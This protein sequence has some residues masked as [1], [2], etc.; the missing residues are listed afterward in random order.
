[1]TLSTPEQSLGF[2]TRGNLGGSATG[3]P[4]SVETHG[5]LDRSTLCTNERR[6]AA[7]AKKDWACLDVDLLPPLRHR[8]QR[9]AS[10]ARPVVFP[11]LYRPIESPGHAGFFLQSVLEVGESSNPLERNQPEAEASKNG[12][13]SIPERPW[14]MANPGMSV[15]VDFPGPQRPCD[16]NDDD[17]A[18][19]DHTDTVV[20]ITKLTRAHP[21]SDDLDDDPFNLNSLLGT[22]GQ[23]K[24]R[25]KTSNVTLPREY[26]M[27]DPS[28]SIG[29]SP[30]SAARTTRSAEARKFSQEREVSF[31]PRAS[32]KLQRS[33]RRGHA[34]SVT[35]DRRP[36]PGIA[37]ETLWTRDWGRDE[38]HPQSSA[39]QVGSTYK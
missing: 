3:M 26:D 38:I 28:W 30:G 6:R 16:V 14:E 37:G 31:I 29:A 24:K 32:Q 17:M 11:S 12:S 21:S 15:P 36:S 19:L 34:S 9:P 33:V 25:I 1:M 10:P 2:S 23:V 39:S 7:L 4:C 20:P 35:G 27:F 5:N 18:W 22:R 13:I 8:V